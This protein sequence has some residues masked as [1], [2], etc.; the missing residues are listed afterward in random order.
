MYNISS[1]Y[2]PYLR[3]TF[4]KHT[5]KLLGAAA[6][7]AIALSGCGSSD[8]TDADTTPGVIPSAETA[9]TPKSNLCAAVDAIDMSSLLGKDQLD[10][11]PC[12]S[13]YDSGALARAVWTR[14][15]DGIRMSVTV[16]SNAGGD[17]KYAPFQYLHK[18]SE[19][20]HRCTV[21]VLGST[22]DCL[23]DTSLTGVYSVNMGG[24][25]INVWQSQEDGTHV[26]GMPVDANRAKQIRD[27]TVSTVV[28][29]L[30]G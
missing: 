25:Y 13:D 1:P 8:H 9:P 23:D 22:R 17:G 30:Y 18:Y 2:R 4:V 21:T 5:I 6:V 29:A 10:H 24:T 28:P 16:I 27:F 12:Y 14:Q 7:L 15:S 11:R 3:E 20:Q 19:P 26:G